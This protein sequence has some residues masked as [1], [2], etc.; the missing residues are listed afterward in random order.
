[1]KLSFLIPLLVIVL[2]SATRSLAQEN[3]KTKEQQEFDKFQQ[4]I[5]KG[6][7][8]FSQRNDSLFLSFLNKSWKE[9][10]LHEEQAKRRPKPI[11]QPSV[12]IKPDSAQGAP[13][14]Q[15]IEIIDAEKNDDP[16]ESDPL[17]LDDESNLAPDNPGTTST[18]EFFGHPIPLSKVSGSL[19]LPSISTANIIE[20]YE[21]YLQNKELIANANELIRE[22]KELRLN[23]WGV[24]QLMMIASEYYFSTTNNRVLFTWITLLRN[25]YDVKIGY[26]RK[27]IFL[28]A[29]LTCKIFSN[30]Y[31]ELNS[32][33]FYI[34]PLPGQDAPTEGIT[35][36]EATYPGNTRLLS[37]R[38]TELPAL[39]EYPTTR[40]LIYQGD[41]LQVQL[42]K[43]LIQFLHSY[44]TCE[45]MIYFNTPLSEK[46]MQSL[47][48]RLLPLLE[49]KTE[50][51]QVNL[52]LEF[53]Q[54]AFP[55]K[56]DDQQFGEERY[57]FGDES[58]YFPF[59]DCEDRAVIFVKL[60]K[61]Y[62]GLKA[63]GLD[64]P[65]HV[66]TAIKFSIQI[67]G[68]FLIFE[69][70][71]YFICDPTYIGAKPGMAMEGMQHINPIIIACE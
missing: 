71:N 4:E 39:T 56:T 26:D 2:L 55:Y 24:V 67:P 18:M 30:P 37:L 47:D 59:T 69:G 51:E 12:K 7:S 66:S 42:S 58:L 22:G 16:Q 13:S 33:R 65:D 1:M 53:V 62:T 17:Q 68:D 64:Y 54:R 48:K 15:M 27:Q 11:D 63:I 5:T 44:P 49:G 52:L 40:T 8:Q 25:G 21:K 61:R 43:S 28:L 34:I 20:F 19:S 50:Q 45:L 38:L 32:Q 14:K 36:F 70:D 23:D 35:S 29:N 41:A 3:R 57:L 31:I 60:I 9:F 10:A 6:Y 46:A